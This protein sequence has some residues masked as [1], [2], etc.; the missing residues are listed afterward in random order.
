[1]AAPLDV[2]PLLDAV[3]G[4]TWPSRIRVRAGM[5]GVHRAA[6]RGTT[7]EFTEYRSY[8]QGDDPRRI[9][10]RLLA[11]S[12]RAFIRVTDERAW[13]PTWLVVDASASMA[14]PLGESQRAPMVTWHPSG[15][16][17][18]IPEKWTTARQLGIALG[19]IAHASGD[20]VG[21]LVNTRPDSTRLSPITRR[22]VVQRIARTL[23]GIH[24]LAHV[25][26]VPTAM[27][28]RTLPARVRV[29]VLTDAL[30]DADALAAACAQ[31]VAAGSAV[32][33][34]HVVHPQELSPMGG[35][36]RAQDPDNPA[37]SR[38]LAPGTVA[39]YQRAFD[40]W[41]AQ[42]ATRVRAGGGGYVEVVCG[43]D[44]ARAVRDIVAA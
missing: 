20:P 42:T 41:R 21:V 31:R 5:P 2:G 34:V 9:D 18:G 27:L 33:V 29:V 40:A 14:F 35:V 43:A 26:T 30:D 25:G 23:D 39:E 38:T 16:D 8:R 7:G 19:A 22:G 3:R 37:L 4:V 1:M 15:D 17:D 6:Q 44:T 12:D 36:W 11:R 13:L 28:L 24:P 32:T 10:W